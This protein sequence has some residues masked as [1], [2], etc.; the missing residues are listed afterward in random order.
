MNQDEKR[1]KIYL[2]YEKVKFKNT[3]GTYDFYWD[4]TNKENEEMCLYKIG[5]TFD[6]NERVRKALLDKWKYNVE[7]VICAADCASSKITLALEKMIL[8]SVDIVDR[9]SISNET[10]MI[11][12]WFNDIKPCLKLNHKVFI[13]SKAELVFLTKYQTIK[14]QLDFIDMMDFIK[15]NNIGIPYSFNLSIKT[16]AHTLYTNKKINHFWDNSI[17][18]GLDCLNLFN[19]II[20]KSTTQNKN[21]I[22]YH[23]QL[24]Y[25]LNELMY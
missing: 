20:H 2:I 16:I 22:Q 17:H 10:I 12:T 13:W 25:L 15:D 6:I 1:T 11:N 14:S 24:N 7:R 3:A 21:I 4:N 5:R 9:N 19:I 23:I 8:N 18:N